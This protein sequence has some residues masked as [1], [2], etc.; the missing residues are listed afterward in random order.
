MLLLGSVTADRSTRYSSEFGNVL[1]LCLASWVRPVFNTLWTQNC[2]ADGDNQLLRKLHL[3][4][5]ECEVCN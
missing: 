3:Y 2:K 1:L 5:R 4:S